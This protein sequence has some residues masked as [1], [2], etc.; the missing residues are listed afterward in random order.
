MPFSIVIK[1]LSLV[2]VQFFNFLIASILSSYIFIFKRKEVLSM[3]SPL[4][5]SM[6]RVLQVS[7]KA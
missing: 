5:I 3:H 1:T 2:K 7:I 4:P 6:I